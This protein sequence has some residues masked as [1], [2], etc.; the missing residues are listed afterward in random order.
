MTIRD[1]EII[2]DKL[3]FYKDLDEAVHLTLKTGFVPVHTTFRNGKV[4]EVKEETLIFNDERLGKVLIFLKE[5]L[6]VDKREE[7]R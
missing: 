1:E 4:L 6:N 5:I 7:R 2:R 3:N